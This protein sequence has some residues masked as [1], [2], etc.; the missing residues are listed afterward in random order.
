MKPLVQLAFVVENLLLQVVPP[1]LG[2]S[3][4][5]ETRRL[6]LGNTEEAG[7]K[8]EVRSAFGLYFINSL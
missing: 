2:N 7:K 4:K 6:T 5:V 1:N 8:R 3:P